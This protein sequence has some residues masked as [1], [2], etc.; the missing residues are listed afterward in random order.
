LKARRGHDRFIRRLETEFTAEDKTYRGISSD[1]S[2]SGLF[3]RTQHAFSPDTLIDIIIH[4]PD[5]I[6]VKLR[7]M[8]RRSI[9]TPVVS[10]K[11]GMGIEILENDSRYVN[12]VKSVFPGSLED[13][14][15][16]APEPDAPP[17]RER[18]DEP[19]PQPPPPEFTIIACPNC[20]VKNRVITAKLSLGPKCG[21]CGY[22]LT[23]RD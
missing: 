18:A 19:P 8:V 22:L 5:S 1:L 15:S 17:V 10:I 12:F 20:S 13:I 2:I 21:K 14:E 16:T 11:N 9:K 7:G 23:A 6:D 3:I 4:L